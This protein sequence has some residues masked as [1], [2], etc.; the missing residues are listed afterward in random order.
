MFNVEGYGVEEG[1]TNGRNLP[2]DAGDIRD[3][4]SIPGSGRSPGEGDGH[5]LQHS[6]LGSP[7]TEE[8]GR[9]QSIVAQTVEHD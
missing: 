9:L 3:K 1:G 4:S 8:P 5:P 7:W 6:C 2:A